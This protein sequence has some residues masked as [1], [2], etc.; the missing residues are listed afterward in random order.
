MRLKTWPALAVALAIAPHAAI[1][2]SMPSTE[3]A[4]IYY[5]GATWESKSPSAAA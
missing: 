5:P 3:R 1:A 4:G 2:Q